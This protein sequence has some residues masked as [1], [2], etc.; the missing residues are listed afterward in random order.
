MTAGFLVQPGDGDSVWSIGGRFTR[1]VGGDDTADRLSILEAVLTR[2]SEPRL[3]IHHREDEAFY[4][5]D[6]Q[7]SFHVGDTVLTAG[8]GALALAPMGIPHTFTV[9]VEPSR[10]LVITGPAG[11]ERFIFELGVP[12]TSDEPPAGLAPPPGPVILP[13]AERHG[14]EIV[15]PRIRDTEAS[16]T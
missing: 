6:G 9:D 13:V 10:V 16:T 1:K 12:A 3:H 5:L 14:I 8:T 7:L 15:G 4:I 11:F 2:T